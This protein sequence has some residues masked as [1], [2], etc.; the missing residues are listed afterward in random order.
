MIMSKASSQT[1]WGNPLALSLNLN[2]LVVVVQLLNVS[3]FLRPQGLQYARLPCPSLSPGVCSDS[4]PLSQRCYL[5]ILSSATLF[6]SIRVFFNES[7]LP[8]T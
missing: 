1:D 7:A 8:I 5:A 3:D 4:C 6:F 2:K